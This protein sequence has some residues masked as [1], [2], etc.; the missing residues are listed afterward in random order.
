MMSKN[1][2]SKKSQLSEENM[3][4]YKRVDPKAFEREMTMVYLQLKG[5]F[6]KEHVASMNS[7]ILVTEDMLTPNVKIA[8]SE[9]S[10]VDG[11]IKIPVSSIKLIKEGPKQLSITPSVDSVNIPAPS[12]P[13]EPNGKSAEITIEKKEIVLSYPNTKVENYTLQIDYSVEINIPN[14]DVSATIVT[15]E[16]PKVLSPVNVYCVDT[17]FTPLEKLNYTVSPKVVV[18]SV[19]TRCDVT[20][21]VNLDID[22]HQIAVI[23]ANTNLIAI[24]ELHAEKVSSILPKSVI[25][26]LD[27]EAL[28][29]INDTSSATPISVKIVKPALDS[30]PA[31][32]LAHDISPIVVPVKFVTTST[33]DNADILSEATILKTYIPIKE[34]IT[35]SSTSPVSFVSYDEVKIEC[36]TLALSKMLDFSI[37]P[38]SVKSVRVPEADIR[39]TEYNKLKIEEQPKVV[40]ADAFFSV[41]KTKCEIPLD[42]VYGITVKIE[43]P[44]LEDVSIPEFIREDFALD[45]PTVNNLSDIEVELVAD[46]SFGTV[47]VPKFRLVNQKKSAPVEAEIVSALIPI[48]E[49]RNKDLTTVSLD[50]PARVKVDLVR[51]RLESELYNLVPNSK[52]RIRID[53][54]EMRTKLEE[55]SALAVDV[56][57]VAVPEAAKELSD[58]NFILG[59]VEGKKLTIIQ[60]PNILEMWN[61]MNGV[62]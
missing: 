23:S 14:A 42:T 61:K 5:E 34:V 50:E 43:T 35:S 52:D 26:G 24:P 48:P 7:A 21:D 25:I 44:H 1:N 11:E 9:V 46:V 56:I 47:S 62:T 32:N 51:P 59:S 60:P 27:K 18:R 29:H 38:I 54:P 30:H 53:V 33:A 55:S 39:Q 4:E 2:T 57:S 17:S 31:S 58:N 3:P 45:L 40:L 36:S 37:G 6:S 20:A 19:D 28:L 13:E 41:V 22:S 16:N 8:P 49:I 15:L 10:K 12:L